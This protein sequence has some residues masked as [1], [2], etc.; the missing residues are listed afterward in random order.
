MGARVCAAAHHRRQGVRALSAH[1]GNRYQVGLG[2]RDHGGQRSEPL[3]QGSCRDRGNSGNCCQ[4]GFG[5]LPE[6]VWLRALGVVRPV[7]PGKALAVREAVEPQRRVDGP[8]RP[9]KPHPDPHGSEAGAANSRR[10]D[11]A[12]VHVDPF[13]K[14]V[15]IP[16]RLPDPADLGPEPAF[17]QGPVEVRDCLPFDEDL[18]ADRVVAGGQP[19]E[20]E[21]SSEITQARDNPASPLEDVDHYN[22]GAR[23]R[24]GPNLNPRHRSACKQLAI[25]LREI[26]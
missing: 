12:V 18:A 23:N 2:R 21:S 15:G 20:L 24:D 7:A 1:A 22:R 4:H 6:L 8:R 17:D 14:Q 9:E 11:R 10:R 25:S 5:D 19:F 3:Q 26:A 16:A 13:D